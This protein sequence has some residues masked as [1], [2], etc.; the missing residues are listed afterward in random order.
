MC[1][2]MLVCDWGAT[3]P[4]EGFLEESGPR[5]RIVESGEEDENENEYETTRPVDGR[6]DHR[7][8]EYEGS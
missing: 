1:L 4:P 2:L 6:T 5:R 3:T 8:G 7:L